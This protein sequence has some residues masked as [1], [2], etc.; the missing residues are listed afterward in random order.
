M[1]QRSAFAKASADRLAEQR[2]LKRG[3]FGQFLRDLDAFHIRTDDPIAMAGSVIMTPAVA[4]TKVGNAIGGEFSD[5][6][7]EPLSEGVFKYTVR[8][9]KSLIGNTASAVKNL[10]TLHP[11]RAAG[12]VLKGGWMPWTL[13][14]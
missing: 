9:I 11:L 13:L 2:L 10:L 12:N 3:D 5:R 1:H 14:P 6:Q 8:D 7:A 4:V